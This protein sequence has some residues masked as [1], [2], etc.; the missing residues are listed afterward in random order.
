MYYFLY[1]MY[2]NQHS[3]D[4]AK[5]LQTI[6]KEY[7]FFSISINDF[8]N[9]SHADLNTYFTTFPYFSNIW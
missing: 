7:S 5:I 6:F 9:C 3:K 8:I 4:E 1:H 2:S